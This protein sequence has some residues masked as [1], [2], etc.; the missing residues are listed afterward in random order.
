MFGLGLGEIL[1]I[2]LFLLIFIGPKKLPELARGLGKGIREF[3]K[4]SQDLKTEI[5][6][7]ESQE[8]KIEK[9]AETKTDQ[10]TTP[11]DASEDKNKEAAH[12]S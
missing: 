1:I 2:C 8:Q 3:Q 12:L 6:K 10:N 5:M 11:S 9:V 7:E 4:A